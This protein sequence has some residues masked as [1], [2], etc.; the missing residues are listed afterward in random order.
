MN[1]K[2]K[3]RIFAVKQATK[4]GYIECRMGVVDLSYPTSKLRKG[5]VQGNMGDINP[6]ITCETGVCRIE[7]KKSKPLNPNNDGSCRT[8]KAQYAN[9]STAN[10]ERDDTMDATGVIDEKDFAIRKLTPK[11]CWRLM[12]F[13]DEQFLKAKLGGEKY[14][15]GYEYK[16][17]EFNAF[18]EKAELGNKIQKKYGVSNSQLYKQA[19]N[20]IVT[21]VLY[22]IYKELYTAMPYLFDN[23]KVSSYFSGIGAFE[24]ALDRFY[25]NDYK[26]KELSCLK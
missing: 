2:N 20:S 9:T 4:K 16:C 10:L 7:S 5:R 21:D 14:L 15:K 12:G 3:T 24:S 11:E 18:E 26:K 19:G 22:H 1:T 13:T 8:I 23:L 6:T 25:E 17:K